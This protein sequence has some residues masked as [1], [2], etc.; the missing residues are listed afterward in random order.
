MAC[1]ERKDRPGGF[2]PVISALP[3]WRLN[4]GLRISALGFLCGLKPQGTPPTGTVQGLGDEVEGGGTVGA[5][6]LGT[7]PCGREVPH[8]I[9]P[10]NK[11]LR[12]P[13]GP[14]S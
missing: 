11:P 8:R 13:S 6:A 9:K 4:F 12:A 7:L 3:L 1:V 2:D 5:T 14:D 10:K